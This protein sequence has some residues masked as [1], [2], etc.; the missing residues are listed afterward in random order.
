[1]NECPGL[2][3]S[4]NENRLLATVNPPPGHPVLDSDSARALLTQAG[5]GEW[6]V[7]GESLE[8]L[9]ALYNEGVTELEL[10]LGERRDAGFS[11]EIVPDAMQAW[12]AVAPACGGKLLEPE[13]IFL[14]L[15]EAGV[16]YGIDQP[17]IRAACAAN[18]ECRVLAAAGTPAQNGEDA[19]FELLVAEVR[20]RAPQISENGLIDFRELGANPTVAAE[21][22]LMRRYPPT[23][24]TAGHNV[25]GEVIE[26]VAGKDV[27]FAEKLVGAYVDPGD[28]NLL[29]AAF[30]GQLV[31]QDPND[32]PASVL[33]ERI[34]AQ[35]AAAP[36]AKRG[37]KTSV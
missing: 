24:G 20:D 10:A 17:T 7:S 23:P 26:P 8:K 6:A 25:R 18:A 15:G 34:K 11:L 5:Y 12:V 21:Q 9:V 28:A 13:E 29:R 37:R 31:P 19:R 22:E 33:L 27:Y 1:M 32:E 16:T 2:A 14:A 30:S 4:E 3:F 35:R 36:K